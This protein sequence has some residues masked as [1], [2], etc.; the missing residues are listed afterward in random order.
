[1]VWAWGRLSSPSPFVLPGVTVLS[2]S[3]VSSASR[4]VW[5][6][7]CVSAA[8]ACVPAAAGA[9]GSR[10]GSG[11]WA[12][13]CAQNAAPALLWAEEHPSAQGRAADGLVRC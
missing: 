11:A 10:R 1:M 2:C 12:E 5:F 4:S 13:L 6:H 8:R 7:V 3:R 9:P